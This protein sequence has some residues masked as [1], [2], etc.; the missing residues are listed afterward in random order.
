MLKPTRIKKKVE[1][2]G[3][4][5]R[6]RSKS[7]DVG[8]DVRGQSSVRDFFPQR[9]NDRDDA[10]VSLSDSSDEAKSE[11]PNDDRN[12][13][14]R[15]SDADDE[16][17]GSVESPLACFDPDEEEEE[18]VS[19]LL[20][21]EIDLLSDFEDVPIEPFQDQPEED[22]ATKESH[23][24]SHGEPLE[25][26]PNEV[27]ARAKRA[28][29]KKRKTPSASQELPET[30]E[31][32]LESGVRK[33]KK[34]RWPKQST[35]TTQANGDNR[36]KKKA[37]K[38]Q[39]QA[40]AKKMKK[41]SSMQ[42]PQQPTTPQPAVPW[43][44]S[45]SSTLDVM[46]YARCCKCQMILPPPTGVTRLRQK[47][48]GV[49][50]CLVCNTRQVQANRVLQEMNVMSRFKNLDKDARS[51]FWKAVRNNGGKANIRAMV[52][53]TFKK[54]EKHEKKT[55]ASGAY[56]PISWYEKQG[57][58][59]DVIRNRC[60]DSVEHPIL[61]KCYRLEILSA[62]DSSIY[63]YERSDTFDGEYQDDGDEGNSR[64]AMTPK[65][66]A[67]Q[68]NGAIAMQRNMKQQFKELEMTVKKNKENANKVLAIVSGE[69][70]ITEIVTKSKHYKTIGK[71]C[72]PVAECF[73]DC[74]KKLADA[75]AD[76]RNAL[77]SGCAIS[78]T[79]EETQQLVKQCG[80]QRS[81]LQSLM[82]QAA[83]GGG[84]VY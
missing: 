59:G 13:T 8:A 38:L 37:K 22:A 80:I 26:K 42:Q 60:T 16:F 1:G 14:D 83:F 19:D 2:L 15:W 27:V 23:C 65:V 52:K 36:E 68:R 28:Q 53:E 79:L 51:E 35:D 34:K 20:A 9:L 7:A 4:M 67:D 46:N 72:E 33:G 32:F 62:E 12:G 48:K 31:T 75:K 41:V 78:A 77:A 81:F 71:T 21:R 30:L 40:A 45:S 3:I 47:C 66:T 18:D 44:P 6:R 69:L 82:T 73:A 39:K 25:E 61:G 11:A 70:A 54:Y 58:D 24:E 17:P 57:Y 29:K 64:P 43:L 84:S 76:A 63:G 74:I 50:I 56:Q 10:R 5:G 49:N 55:T